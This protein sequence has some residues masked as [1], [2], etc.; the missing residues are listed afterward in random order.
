MSACSSSRSPSSRASA[1]KSARSSRRP[2]PA[3][4]RSTTRLK[5][6]QDTDHPRN[7]EG[8]LHLSLRSAARPRRVAYDRPPRRSGSPGPSSWT[9]PMA[10]PLSQS[11]EDAVRRLNTWRHFRPPALI[12][13][14]NAMATQPNA[15]AGALHDRAV[16]HRA[17]RLDDR[18]AG[19]DALVLGRSATICSTPIAP[20]SSGS[21]TTT[22]SSPTRPSCRRSATR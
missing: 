1:P 12:G 3:R 11:R 17:V 10:G 4:S 20:A 6:A 9:T 7:E 21:A 22:S 13:G 5:Q 14:G 15:H 19:A 8:R 18:A 2:S 16:D